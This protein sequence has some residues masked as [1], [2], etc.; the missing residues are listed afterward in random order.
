MKIYN[1]DHTDF[2]DEIMLQLALLYHCVM[3]S[4]IIAYRMDGLLQMYH[5]RNNTFGRKKQ[6]LRDTRLLMKRVITNMER[7]FDDDFGRICSADPEASGLRHDF[8]MERSNEIIQLLLI[9]YSRI[10]GQMEKNKAIQK[11]LLNFKPSD[12]AVDIKDVLKYYDFKD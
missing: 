11:A 8:L 7:Y 4:E 5:E 6:I 3:S 9:Y 1:K 12:I 2:S 10:D